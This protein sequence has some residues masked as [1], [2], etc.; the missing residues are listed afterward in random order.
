MQRR[1]VIIKHKTNDELYNKKAQERIKLLERKEVNND[2][3]RQISDKEKNS[4]IKPDP[5]HLDNL[6]NLRNK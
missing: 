3:Q 6:Q 2:Y 4:L 1:I 5:K